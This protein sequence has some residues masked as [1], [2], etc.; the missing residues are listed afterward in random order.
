MWMMLPFVQCCEVYGV[1]IN[2]KG[3]ICKKDNGL[4]NETSRLYIVFPSYGRTHKYDASIAADS[5]KK[6]YN[7]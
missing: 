6:D 7:A 2:T 3:V 4:Q 1:V 5:Q